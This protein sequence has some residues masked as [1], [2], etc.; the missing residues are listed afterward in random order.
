MKSRR[1]WTW[2]LTAAGLLQISL[3]IAHFGLPTMFDWSSSVGDSLPPLQQWA[4]LCSTS[5]G[6]QF[7]GSQCVDDLRGKTQLERA[8]GASN[9]SHAPFCPRTRPLL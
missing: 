2:T 3:A 6:Q 7:F 9:G 5:P 8:I 1:S 4:L